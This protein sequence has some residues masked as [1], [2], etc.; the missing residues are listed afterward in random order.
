MYRSFGNGAERRH[1][2]FKAFLSCQD[3][4]INS[5]SR[6]DDPNWK[7]RPLLTWINFIFPTIWLLAVA[8][9]VNEMTMAFKGQHRDK[10]RIIYK[11]EGGDF[12]VDAL[13]Q[14]GYTYQ[15]WMRNNRAPSKCLKQGMS[16]L[17]SRVMVLF[18]SIEDNHHQCAMNDLYNSVAFCK[19]AYNHKKKVLCHSVARSGMRGISKYVMQKEVKNRK[20]QIAVCRTVKAAMLE[21][22]PP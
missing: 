6:D 8:F 22:D 1:H 17:H 7:V 16:P 11:A 20:E 2:Y 12:Q 5:P 13:C 9:S 14:E 4:R 10:K 19:A 15:I 3:L 18:D 21:G